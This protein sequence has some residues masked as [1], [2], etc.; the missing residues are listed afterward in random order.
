[1]TLYSNI[2]ATS[3]GPEDLS[4]EG[5]ADLST[6]GQDDLSTEGQ[7]DLSTEGQ[8][9]LSDLS[10]DQSRPENSIELL[11]LEKAVR[12]FSVSP[13][14]RT[15]DLS[16]PETLRIVT[17]EEGSSLILEVGGWTRHLVPGASPF[18]QADSGAII[19][20]DVSGE[21]SGGSL[22]LVLVEGE[23]T[24]QQ[25]QQL[26]SLLL[27]QTALP[28]SSQQPVEQQLGKL[29]NG[30]VWGA[31]KLAGG[32]EMGAEKAG[33]LIEYVAEKAERKL[34][35]S[36]E[37]AEV[38]AITRHSVNAA[39]AA[40]DVTVKVSGYVADR[41]GDLTKMMANYLAAKVVVDPN[42]QEEGTYS[43]LV[44]VAKGGLVAYGTVYNGL[45]TSAKVLGNNVKQ[46]SVKVVQHTYG[47]QAGDVFGG[48]V[49][50]AGN[51]AMIFMNVQSL[52]A[53]GLVKKT[54]NDTGTNIAK[55]VID[56]GLGGKEK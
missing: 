52:G 53:K 29:G 13:S 26:F 22:G 44:D 30:L 56:K 21:Q 47:S 4:I 54:A 55:N 3:L 50:A 36:E 14:G 41:V 20:P 23:V 35:R 10:P 40:T 48:A 33:E 46:N 1:M 9:D 28:P 34:V 37:D 18:L 32:I 24:E 38:G 42:S 8:D 19:F 2:S 11:K 43:S 25:R 51:P 27:Q 39:V 15:S 17:E 5:Q 45:E 12:V 6:E 7:D 31:E 49:T 16:A